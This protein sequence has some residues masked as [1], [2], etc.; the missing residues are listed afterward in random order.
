MDHYLRFTGEIKTKN[1]PNRILPWSP[2]DIRIKSYD[3]IVHPVSKQNLLLKQEG[4]S[5]LYYQ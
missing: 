3:P 5:I 1:P 4:Y 2:T